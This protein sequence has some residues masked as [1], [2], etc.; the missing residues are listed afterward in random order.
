MNKN[1]IVKL[2]LSAVVLTV[3]AISVSGETA[4]DGAA[5]KEERARAKKAFSAAKQAEKLLAKGNSAK[6]LPFAE[7]AVSIDLYNLEYRSLL[8]RSYMKEGRFK[9]AERTLMDVM[10]LGQTDARTL[11]SIALTRIAQG[12]VDSAIALVDANQGILPASDYGLALAL[13]GETKRGITV[14]TDSIRADNSTARTR[15]NLALAY[16]L[17]GR[18]RDSQ[19]MAMQDMPKDVV[20]KRIVEWAQFTRPGAYQA[21]IANLLGVTPQEDIGQPASLALNAV[22]G[23]V[24]LAAAQSAPVAVPVAVAAVTAPNAPVA[25]LAAVG[26]APVNLPGVAPEDVDTVAAVVA[27]VEQIQAPLIKAPVGPSKQIQPVKVAVAKPVSQPVAKVSV[28]PMKLALADTAPAAASVRV[29]G[30]HLVQ[31]GAYTSSDGAKHAWGQLTKKYRVL[32][33]FNSAS[34]SVVVNGKR[35]VRL[36]AMGFGN[37][38]SANAVCAQIK[39]GGGDCIVK[40]MSGAVVGPVRMASAK[41]KARPI[42]RIASR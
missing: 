34:S 11:V 17:D 23:E 4:K 10:E 24:N 33:S 7:M 28:K 35:F 16:A 9:S 39:S 3:P 30:S 25:E 37:A 5:S 42:R 19:V 36:A 27:V 38:S 22:A 41:P 32:Q 14:L 31:L 8:A 2:A 21:R 18:W 29:G 13:A 15:Q 1:L 26:P 40:N 12:K 20:D 6:A